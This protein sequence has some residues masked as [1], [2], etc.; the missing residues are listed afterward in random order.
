MAERVTRG[1]GLLEGFLARRRAAVAR[2]L[3]RE[4]DHDGRILDVGCGSRP[5]FLRGSGFR[6]RYG[7][8]KLVAADRV[9]GD[10]IRLIHHDV[11]HQPRLPFDDASFDAVTMLAVFE[12]I[13]PGPLAALLREIR[14]VLRPGAR[15][16][17][18]TP[19][20]WTDPVL[21]TLARL[22]LVSP[23]EIDEHQDAYDHRV[24]RRFL[25]DAGFESDRIRTGSFELFM[26]IWA[27]ADA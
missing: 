10:G 6:E 9:D 14:R 17:L 19:A 18:T 4:C 27:T 12:H 23:E 5:L 15:L 3:L 8:D 1:A 24:I 13:E 26:N 2:R 25:T 21:R 11:R 20:G 7:L 16:V 22:R